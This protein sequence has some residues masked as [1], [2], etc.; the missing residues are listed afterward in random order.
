[1]RSD[2]PTLRSDGPTWPSTSTDLG[3]TFRTVRLDVRTSDLVLRTVRLVLRTSDAFQQVVLCFV[4]LRILFSCNL[5]LFHVLFL[6][7][8]LVPNN[9]YIQGLR[10]YIV[11]IK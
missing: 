10:Q 11:L 6:D 3:C 8:S 1:M 4:F 9:T 2:G 5:P 7:D